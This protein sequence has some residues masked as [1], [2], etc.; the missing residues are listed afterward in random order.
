MDEYDTIKSSLNS[1]IETFVFHIL[2]KVS[3]SSFRLRHRKTGESER[4]QD[5]LEHNL[6]L[7]CPS[8]SVDMKCRQK[9]LESL[10]TEFCLIILQINGVIHICLIMFLFLI[11]LL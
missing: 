4:E 7:C 11:H 2:C 1:E 9:Q 5:I 8:R 6:P 10:K 3:Q